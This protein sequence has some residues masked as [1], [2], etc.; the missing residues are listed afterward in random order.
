[1]GRPSASLPPTTYTEPAATAAQ[2]RARAEPSG[3]PGLHTPLGVSR[4]SLEQSV[5]SEASVPPATYHLPS[6]TAPH[7][8]MREVV[9]AA[10]NSHAPPIRASTSSPPPADMPPARQRQLEGL[11]R[12]GDT[13]CV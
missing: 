7:A 12:S 8:P 11:R 2:A 5:A 13:S 6:T 10:A 3:G 9:S 1:M 4:T